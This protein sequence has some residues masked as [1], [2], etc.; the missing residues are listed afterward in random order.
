MVTLTTGDL[1]FILTQIQLSEAHANGADLSDLISNPLLPWGIRTVDGSYNN[2]LDGKEHFGSADQLMPRLLVPEFRDGE[3]IPVGAPGGEPGTPTSYSQTNGFVYDSQPRTISNLIVDQSGANPAAQAAAQDTEEFGSAWLGAVDPV[4][5]L[6]VL[7]AGSDW[8]IAAQAPDEGISA[9]FNPW[10]T[11]FGQFFDHGLDL[12]NKGGNGTIVMPLQP[13]DPLYVEGSN[14]NF[15]MLTRATNDPGPDGI[16]GTADDI[17]EQSNKTTPFVDQNQTYTSHA[18]HQVFLREYEIRD[19]VPVATGHLLDGANGGLANWGEVKAQASAM[20]GIELSDMDALNVPLLLTDQYGKFIPGANGLPQLVTSV[21]VNGVV[22]GVEEGNLTTPTSTAGAER[23][24]HAFLDDIAHT[25]V[26]NEEGTHDAA[27]LAE[28]FITGDGRGN[29]NIALTSVHHVFHSEHNRMVEHVKDLVLA[30]GDTD[31]IAQWQIE[32]GVWN[33]EYLFQAARFVTEMQYQHLVFEEFART[34]QPA[35]DVFVFSHNVEIDAAIF[36]EFAHVVYR[37][38]HSM[39]TEDVA[40]ENKDG[41]D[42][43]TTLLNAFLNPELFDAGYANADA[44]AGA[45]VRGLTREPGNEI[46]EFVTSTLRN[47]LLGLPLDLAAINI[48]RGRDTG[49]PSLNNAREQFYSQ[50]GDTQLKP[51]TSWKDFAENIKNP[52]SLI[53]F[54]AAYGTHDTVVNA[55]GTA[56]KRAAAWELVMGAPMD[57]ADA[58]NPLAAD[59]IEFLTSTGAWANTETGLNLV[60]FW[61][62]GL[63]EQNMPFGGMLGSTFSFVF[64]LQLEQLQVGDRFYYLSRTQGMNLLTELENNS[65]TKLIMA[66]TDLGDNDS[67]HLPGNIFAA[68][69]YILE[70]DETRQKDYNPDDPTSRDPVRESGGNLND[71]VINGGLVPLVERGDNFLKFNSDV[72][73]VLGARGHGEAVTLIGGRGDD[74][75]WGSEHNDRLE[76]GWGNDIIHGGDGDDII[77]DMGSDAEGRIHGDGGNDVIVA[78]SGFSLIF[79]GP[80]KDFI[81]GGRD[82]NDIFGGTGDDFIHAGIGPGFAMGNEG[83]DWMEGGDSF[84]TLAGDNSELFFNSSIIGH[85]VLIGGGNDTDFDAESGDDIMVQ[86][87]GINRNEGMFGFDWVSFKNTPENSQKGHFVDLS[88]EERQVSGVYVDMRT[89]V[90]TTDFDDILRDRFDQVEALSGSHY[91]DILIGDDRGTGDDIE[92]ELQIGETHALT[93]EGVERIDNLDELLG[94]WND[95]SLTNPGDIIFDRGNLIL[96]G[97]GS[98]VMTGLAGDDIIDGDAWLNVKIGVDFGNNGTFD[99]FHERMETLRERMVSGEINPGELHIV[100]EIL[101]DNDADSVDTAVFT[102]A[103]DEYDITQNADGS[104]LVAHDGGNG[105]DGTDLVR[106]VEVLQFSDQSVLIDES[107]NIAAV[108]APLINDTTPTQ[109]Q[110][111]TASQGNITD[112]NGTTGSTFSFQWQVGLGLTFANIAGATGATFTPTGDQVGQQLRVVITFNDDSGFLETLTSE[113]TDIVGMLYLGTP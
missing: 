59:R 94:I 96:G 112:L 9:P 81:M 3:A 57:P 52:A 50:T 67:T 30:T 84:T 82:E 47:S 58:P 100:R 102:G 97:A 88:L 74:T 38:G 35:V 29:E 99:E 106:N 68:V 113:A 60:D 63:A 2:F 111:L 24:G 87:M 41:T 28:H 62:G 104:W 61:I 79:G 101:W 48:A 25:A 8:F 12:I 18:S 11:F 21:D 80:D 32:P 109:G 98:D 93:R 27:L 15:L 14:T 13:D 40:R 95:T 4:T 36:A 45:L 78:G 42:N 19:G 1:D 85:D 91:D 71:Q 56:D 73:A 46:D 77:T 103:R 16:L 22:T 70:L 105:V 33:G 17:R 75:L 76:G 26:P 86:G 110:T 66:N 23:T 43:S 37:F 31:Y 89:P 44:A 107:V 34:I 90:F 72:H 53:N 65:F 108:G 51:Y 10:M 54:I 20:L 92:D 5:G 69:N 7:D 55:V 83:N 49:V 6:P 39:L 64:E